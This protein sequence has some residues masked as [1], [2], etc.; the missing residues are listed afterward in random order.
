M[1]TARRSLALVPVLLLGAALTGCS[2]DGPAASADTVVASDSATAPAPLPLTAHVLT[3]LAG[4]EAGETQLLDVPAFAE[5]H[6]KTVAE[7]EELGMVAA[8]ATMFD[9]SSGPGTAMS[10]AQQFEEADRAEAEAARLFAVNAEPDRG[11][12]VAPLEVPGIPG[13]QAVT[14]AATQ[15]GKELVAVEIVFVTEAVVHEVFA[16]STVD[17]L[18]VD[19]VVASVTALYEGVAGR[20]VA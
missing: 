2:D 5:E 8:A 17:G 6:G 14:L 1:T 7:L 19:A 10:I 11:T 18:D 16:F 15:G 3:D 12:S 4:F 20:P 13:A 9:P